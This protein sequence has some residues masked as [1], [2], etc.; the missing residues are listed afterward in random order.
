[1]TKSVVTPVTLKGNSRY[2]PTI[3]VTIGDKIMS[4]SGAEGTAKI[5]PSRVQVER[6]TARPIELARTVAASA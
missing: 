5:K 6:T 2:R 4:A 1:M 3:T